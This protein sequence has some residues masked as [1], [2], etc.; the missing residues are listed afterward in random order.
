MH[1]RTE[2]KAVIVPGDAE[3]LIYLVVKDAPVLLCAAVAANTAADG[4]VAYPEK[5]C[6]NALGIQRRSDL[7]QR[8]VNTALLVWAADHHK[9]SHFTYL[10]FC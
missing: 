1:R 9:N 6:I 2:Y 5:V 7:A 4:L 3:E 10:P 8:G